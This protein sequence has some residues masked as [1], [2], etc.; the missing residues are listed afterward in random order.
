MRHHEPDHTGH[1]VAVEQQLVHG[2]VAVAEDVHLHAG[3]QLGG[4]VPRNPPGEGH[5]LEGLQGRLGLRR[6]GVD[7]GELHAQALE[8]GRLIRWRAQIDR[9]IR[10]TAPRIHRR[11]IVAAGRREQPGGQREALRVRLQDLPADLPWVHRRHATSF[12]GSASP[13]SPAIT[14]AVAFAEFTTPGTPAPGW[15]PAPTR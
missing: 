15:V 1:P 2:L 13:R 8:R 3:Q 12:A 6:A 14:R 11:G 10:P 4:V 5:L 7:G 9:I